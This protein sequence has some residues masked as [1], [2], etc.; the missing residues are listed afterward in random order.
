MS[1]LIEPKTL[2]VENGDSCTSAGLRYR[3]GTLC[4]TR[5]GL[6][7]LFAWLLWGDFCFM[8]METVV[9][10]IL[11]LKLRHLDSPNWSIALIMSTLP[12]ILNMTVCPWVSFKSDR[13]RSRWGRRIPFIL[14]TIP[15]LSAFLILLGFSSQIGAMIHP[16]LPAGIHASSSVVTIVCI[17]IFMVGFQFF[18]MFVNSVFWYLF[19]DVVPT[20]FMGRFLG[21]FRIVVGA[22]TALFNFWIFCYA[23]SH[24]TE[25]FVGASVLYAVGFGFMCLNVKE[26]KYPPVAENADGRR[27]ILAE[28]KTY[29]KECYS[30]KYYWKL[31]LYTTCWSVAHVIYVFSVFA[32]Q[33]I[34]LSLGQIGVIGGIGSVANLLLTYPA[35]ALGDRLHPLRVLLWSHRIQLIVAPLSLIWLIYSPSSSIAF[36][37]SIGLVLLAAPVNA[38]IDAMILPMQMRILPSDRF[39]QFASAQALVRSAGCIVGGF[40]SGAFL[41]VTRAFHHGDNFGFRYFPVWVFVWSALAYGFLSCLYRDWQRRQVKASASDCVST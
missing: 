22:T 32:R 6:V 4:Y 41:D 1:V 38:A 17:G 39:G 26:G 29:A 33:D 27:G 20:A 40:L 14:W 35:G 18:N 19:N 8:M 16:L 13:Y 24:M 23:E 7:V 21:L 15:F 30:E 31:F 34:G 25:I 28:I 2:S 11:P 9:P 5:R 10:A 36:V 12:G 37:I 3:V